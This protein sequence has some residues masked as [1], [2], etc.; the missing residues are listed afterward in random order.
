M[1]DRD[2][3]L[4]LLA[5]GR[6]MRP[7]SRLWTPPADVYQTS[8]GWIVKVDLAGITS[9]ELEIDV[10]ETTLCIRG[11]RRDTLCND[12]VSYHQMEITYSRFEKTICFP[13][14]IEQ[15]SIES[16]YRD[17]LLILHLRCLSNTRD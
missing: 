14:S 5:V 8:D 6:R 13:C 3:Y 11:S 2:R 15:D 12:C 10:H 9:S 17:G 16:D 7:S 4:S 1:T